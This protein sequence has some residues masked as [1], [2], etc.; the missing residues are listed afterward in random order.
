MSVCKLSVEK[1]LYSR[2]QFKVSKS[3]RWNN[4]DSALIF[5]R[6]AEDTQAR[7]GFGRKAVQSGREC[8]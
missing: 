4:R 5:Y 6:A 1:I 8:C 3:A 7:E 2:K